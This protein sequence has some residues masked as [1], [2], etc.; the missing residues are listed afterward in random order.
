MPSILFL[1]D[2]HD[3]YRIWADIPSSLGDKWQIVLYDRHE[4]M[5]WAGSE[6]LAFLSAVQRLAPDHCFDVVVAA[7]E[8]AGFAVSAAL[9][10]LAKGVVLFQPTPDSIIEEIETN[11]SAQELEETAS[12]FV[13]IVE[14][15]D[16]TSIERRREAVIGV[17][18]TMYG[19][20]L[21]A[22]DLALAS[23]VIGDH[24]EELFATMMDVKAAVEAGGKLR[25]GPPWSDRLGDIDVPVTVVVNGRSIWLRDAIARRTREVQV[26]VA[27]ARTGFVWLEDRGAAI[28]AIRHM[29]D[30]HA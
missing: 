17:W 28:A 11:L 24:T 27:E 6:D 7:G 20:Y 30:R 5:P 15:L 3:D 18:R 29:V 26:I 9:A 22:G 8:A 13:P 25:P 23:Q 14:A 10:G 1:P 16:E 4:P 2:L 19:P 12:W 21:A